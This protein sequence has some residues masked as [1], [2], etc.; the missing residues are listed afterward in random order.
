MAA[1]SIRGPGP[2]GSSARR[3]AAPSAAAPT[4]AYGDAA[5]SLRRLVIRQVVHDL[6]ITVIDADT[7]QIIR[8]LILDPSRDYHGRNRRRA[9]RGSSSNPAWGPHAGTPHT[10]RRPGTCPR[11]DSNLRP[12][13]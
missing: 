9:Q 5:S 6:H 4:S 2:P 7:G 12:A 8:D 3:V 10:V 1:A 11:Q 13:V